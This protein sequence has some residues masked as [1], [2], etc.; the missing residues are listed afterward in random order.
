MV[1]ELDDGKIYR[2]A[3]Y[4]MEK[5]MVSCRFSLEPTQFPWFSFLFLFILGRTVVKSHGLAADFSPRLVQMAPT[6][7]GGNNL[8]QF[9]LDV[10]NQVS[11]GIVYF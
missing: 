4:L 1:I 9:V 10:N 5:N 7:T 6:D 3:L 8:A 11:I 2:K